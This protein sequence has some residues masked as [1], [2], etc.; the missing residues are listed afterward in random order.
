M[1]HQD[2]AHGFGGDREKV[3]P[4][5]PVHAGLIDQPDVCVVYK[6]RGFNGWVLF[7]SKELRSREPAQFVVNERYQILQSFRI[8]LAPVDQELGDV[9]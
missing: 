4:V 1:I 5:L 6:R 7:E 9:S 3:R 2:A 8:A